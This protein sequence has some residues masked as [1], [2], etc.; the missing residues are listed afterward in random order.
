M[1]RSSRTLSSP[2]WIRS[3][4]SGQ[5]VDGEDAA[6]GAGHQPVVQRQLVG[7]VTALGDLD[8]VDLAD[9]VGDRGVRRGELLTEP[10]VAMDPHD[11]RVLAVLGDEIAGV[12]GHRGVGVVVDLAAGNDRHPL[13]EQA[14][15]GADHA[16]LRLAPL[17]EEDHVMAGQEGVLQLR[18]D[19]L[20]VAEHAVEQRLAGGDAGN[21]VGADLL[22]D[23]TRHPSGVTQ[24]ADRRGTGGHASNLP[25]VHPGHP[26]GALRGRRTHDRVRSSL[27]DV[28]VDDQMY[29]AV[30]E[31]VMPL[32]TYGSSGPYGADVA[33]A[34]DSVILSSV[35]VPPVS[36][37]TVNRDPSG[38]CASRLAFGWI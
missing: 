10:V 7:E 36:I 34:A 18:E 19:G 37:P 6:I 8:R 27:P 26:A 15:Q 33:P 21:R 13:V 35:L 11:R 25:A 17:A 2:T 5:L 38:S 9:Q 3:A 28:Q 30:P 24:L 12:A 1:S 22:L 16:G 31:C 14:G 23:R 29:V 32:G 4:R 20:L